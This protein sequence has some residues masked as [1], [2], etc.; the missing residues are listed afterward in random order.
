[1]DI[2]TRVEIEDAINR[3]YLPEE[4]QEWLDSTESI[5]E[6]LNKIRRSYNAEIGDI[7]IDLNDAENSLETLKADYEDLEELNKDAEFVKLNEFLAEAYV[8]LNLNS[9]LDRERLINALKTLNPKT[10]EFV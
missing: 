2:E 6:F 1:M 5:V 10:Q 4:W 3:N 7:Q 8:D 9:Y